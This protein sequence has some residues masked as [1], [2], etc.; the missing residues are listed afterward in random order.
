MLGGTRLRGSTG[1]LSDDPAAFVRGRR[2][3]RRGLTSK[4]I[5]PQISTARKAP[6]MVCN[7]PAAIMMR[8][9]EPLWREQR[10]DQVHEDPS[11][12]DAGEPIVEDHDCLLE[13][14]AGDGVADR[15]REEAKPKAK[16]DEVQHAD[17]PQKSLQR[18]IKTMDLRLCDITDVGQAVENLQHC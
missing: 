13:T 5:R 18:S 3:G 15:Q 11:S 4:A 7:Q 12:H 8:L 10:V 9:S 1:L 6:L 16:Q 2:C 14:I 17:A